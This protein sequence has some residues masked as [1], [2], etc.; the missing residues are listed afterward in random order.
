PFPETVASVAFE[1]AELSLDEEGVLRIF[2]HAADG[3]G[4]ELAV[5]GSAVSLAEGALI[6]PDG[7]FEAYRAGFAG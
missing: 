7:T 5:G 3:R 2:G 1:L 4:P 6:S